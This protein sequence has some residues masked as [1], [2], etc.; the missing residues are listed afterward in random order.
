VKFDE[1]KIKKARKPL[2][3]RERDKTIAAVYS[4]A[5][6]FNLVQLS[7]WLEGAQD[8]AKVSHRVLGWIHPLQS[9]PRDYSNLDQVMKHVQTETGM[10]IMGPDAFSMESD[11]FLNVNHVEPSEGKPA[12]TR[13]LVHRM[14]APT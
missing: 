1:E 11:W 9:G 12:L 7:H 13:Q 6:E 10:T 8:L 4:G 14:F 5:E 2:W 3:E